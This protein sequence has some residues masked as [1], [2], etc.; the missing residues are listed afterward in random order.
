MCIRDR[1]CS[2]HLPYPAL[3]YSFPDID[4]TSVYCISPGLSSILCIQCPNQFLFLP[5]MVSNTE[6]SVSLLLFQAPA[7]SLKSCNF[8]SSSF[9]SVKVYVSSSDRKYLKHKMNKKQKIFQRLLVLIPLIQINF[10]K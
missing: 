7:H 1:P 10:L 9:F 5:L 3:V 6:L 2:L 4:I 8:L